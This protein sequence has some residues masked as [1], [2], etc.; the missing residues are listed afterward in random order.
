MF[1][2]FLR[3]YSLP[4]T[5]VFL[6]FTLAKLIGPGINEVATSTLYTQP[7]S[8]RWTDVEFTKVAG[9]YAIV[10]IIF[11]AV[12]GGILADRFGRRVILT[13]GFGGYGLVAILFAACPGLW[14]TRW[15]AASYLI[16]SESLN[17]VGS[18]GFL[19][20][21]MR[22]SWTKAAAT[23]FT[24]YLTLSNVSHVIGN[25]AAGPVRRLFLDPQ[26]GAAADMHSYELTFWFV[27]LITLVPLLL[28]FMV[29]PEQVDRA[30][31]AEEASLET[32]GENKATET[33]KPEQP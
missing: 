24:T 16:A 33:S 18:V 30:K 11:G 26:Y 1:G 8:P 23:V 7:L 3:A 29:K 32:K 17:A 20:M 4:T 15:F 25:W 13:V 9:L 12:L 21:A 27:G 2:A 28:L 6:V 10:P 31:D 22:I 5:L 14:D 19:A